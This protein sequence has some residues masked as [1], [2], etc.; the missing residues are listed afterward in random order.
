M[1]AYKRLLKSDFFIRFLAGV[2]ST[3][4]RFVYYTSRWTH[5]HHDIPSEY[6]KNDTPFIGAFWHNR[7]LMNACGLNRKKPFHMLVSKHSDGKIIARTVENF[8]IKIIAGSRNKGGTEAL[9]GM[10]KALK[11]GESV[12][13]TPDGPR[14]PRFIVSDGI[15]ALAKM[16]GAP[17][18]TG[19]Y[20]IKRRK[21]LGSWDQFILALPFSR[22][23]FVWGGPIFV[24]RN[25]SPE[26]IE[27][28]KTTLQKTLCDTSDEAD[29]LCG[30]EPLKRIS[31]TP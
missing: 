4:I 30:H 15:M 23:V 1:K 12:G 31:E 20:G 25:S 17:I 18:I 6:W 7:L 28:L 19:A 29:R 13:I 8:N 9:R 14:G 10:L 24:P 26:Q 27:I 2:A 11:S 21:V 3:Y 5:I 22:G 16:S